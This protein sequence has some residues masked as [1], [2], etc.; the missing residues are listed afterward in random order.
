M[1][2]IELKKSVDQIADGEI[3][4][5]DADFVKQVFEKA[6]QDNSKN[7]FQEYV[8][9]NTQVFDKTMQDIAT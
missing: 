2:D 6:K 1:S 4:K 8:K 7:Y 9:S 5:A 3:S